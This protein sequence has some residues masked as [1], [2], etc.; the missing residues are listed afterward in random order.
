MDIEKND[1]EA[2]HGSGV[3]NSSSAS[4][5]AVASSSALSI[6]KVFLYMFFGLLITTVV[7][8]GV[9]AIVYY[10]LQS[11]IDV[12]GEIELSQAYLIALI[13]SAVAL[14]IDVLVINFLMSKNKSIIVPGI[15]YTVLI[16]VLFS[17][18]V[19]VI[20]WRLLG[21]AL[22]ITALAFLLM[23]GIAFLSKGNLA[24]LLVM[25]IGLF[26]GAGLLA[27]VN[28]IYMLAT[29]LAIETIYWIVE[30]AIFAAIMFVTIFD[31]WNIKKIADAGAMTKNVSLYCAFR[32]YVDFINIF[33]RILYYLAIITG[34]KE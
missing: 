31:L 28:W 6:A 25:A 34:K 5:T 14:L 11:T 26:V 7:A 20:D 23:G 10:N 33:I 27:L 13:A 17:M 19:I 21:M 24:P 18:L 12:S 9:G 1:R 22:G 2:F 16:G 32:I 3:A 8:F 30:F 29:G 15:I 4:S